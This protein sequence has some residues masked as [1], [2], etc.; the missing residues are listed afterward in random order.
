MIVNSTTTAV[1]IT[2]VRSEPD[3]PKNLKFIEP[4]IGRSQEPKEGDGTLSQDEDDYVTDRT[5]GNLT[6]ST[7]ATLDFSQFGLD[8][9]MASEAASATYRT[10]A[11]NY[12]LN[13]LK[14]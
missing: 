11:Q 6:K 5:I 9:T 4:E 14:D 2:V 8:K 7:D 12:I 3:P 1:P 10:K 13:G